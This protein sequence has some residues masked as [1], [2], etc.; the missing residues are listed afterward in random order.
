VKEPQAGRAA[1]ALSPFK[2]GS[3][4]YERDK[5]NVELIV[6]QVAVGEPKPIVAF[7]GVE[8]SLAEL[9]AG[10]GK[11]YDEYIKL[12]GSTRREQV[13]AVVNSS[14]YKNQSIDGPDSLRAK[15]LQGAVSDA[16]QIALAQFIKGQLKHLLDSAETLSPI[17]EE[18]ALSGSIEKWTKEILTS[19][20]QRLES[21]PEFEKSV[22]LRGSTKRLHSKDIKLNPLQ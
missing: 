4:K 5:A 12:V 17:G 21:N 2:I 11:I 18:L 10:E 15:L 13:E 6:Q 8:F 14:A 9:D 16:E 19:Y 7:N 3:P 1:Y 20:G 22:R